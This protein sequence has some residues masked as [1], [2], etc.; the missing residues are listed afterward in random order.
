M[1][2][3]LF[4]SEVTRLVRRKRKTELSLNIEV[5]N[6][7]TF[8][9]F[10][11]YRKPSPSTMIGLTKAKKQLKRDLGMTAALKPYRDVKYNW[12]RNILRKGGYYSEPMK[13]LRYLLRLLGRK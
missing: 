4:L 12:K 1:K 9:I 2:D 7:R 10:P 8:K 13:L 5:Q 3:I 6:E 11:R